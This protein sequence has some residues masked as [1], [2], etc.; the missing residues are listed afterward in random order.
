FPPK[1]IFG[2]F[3]RTSHQVLSSFVQQSWAGGGQ[4]EDSQESS[5]TDRFAKLASLETRFPR[6]LT[7]LPLT[8]AVTGPNTDG[9][10]MLGDLKVSGTKQTFVAF[11]TALR[12]VSGST[13][14]AVTTA[15]A[16]PVFPGVAFRGSGTSLLYVPA[17]TAGFFTFNGTVASALIT[18]VKPICFTRHDNKLWSID[19][20]GKI[21]KSLDGTTWDLVVQLEEDFIPRGLVVG[22]DRS[23]APQVHAVTDSMV[24]A[25]SEA[26]EAAYETELNY[27]PHTYAGVA[28]ERWRTDIYVSIGMGMQRYTLGTVNAVGLDRDEGVGAE[29][30]GYISSLCRGFNDIFIG[31]TATGFAGGTGLMEII[32]DDAED[33]YISATAARCHVTRLTGAGVPATVWIAPAPGGQVTDLY[34]S[35]AQGTYRLY[36]C[37]EGNVYY[38]TLSTDFDNPAQNPTQEYEQSGELTS[39]W[40][41]MGMAVDRM[42]MASIELEVKHATNLETITIEYQI[43]RD[44][45]TGAWRHHTTITEPGHYELQI[46]ENGTLPDGKIRYDGIGFRRMRYR[47]LMERDIADPLARPVLEALIIS[48]LKRMRVVKSYDFTVD[49]ESGQY[50]ST[51][52]LGNRRRAELLDEMIQSEVWIPFTYS[53]EWHMCRVAYSNGRDKT[54]QDLRGHRSV[55]ILIPWEQSLPN[56]S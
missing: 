51:W 4:K 11:G 13:T 1:Q 55:S 6:G 53:D 44:D 41:D 17:G 43:D 25:V 12:R 9:S 5:D 42:T 39:P 26:D 21:H 20:D 38:Q 7:L 37:W 24:F 27:A 34:V 15:P 48:F 52:G 28:F 30:A 47:V 10:A 2:D 23:D 3:N 14:V 50:D 31:T 35:S 19:R 49:C 54:G 56:A 8:H 18:T 33:A 29:F 16:D 45:L 40:L 36:W 22:H 46:G 32:T